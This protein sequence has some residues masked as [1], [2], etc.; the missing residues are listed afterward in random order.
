MAFDTHKLSVLSLQARD[1]LAA[2]AHLLRD[3]LLPR[4]ADATGR[5]LRLVA[6]AAAAAGAA[7][8][9]LPS[10]CRGRAIGGILLI[11]ELLAI[12]VTLVTRRIS[13]N[14]FQDLVLVSLFVQWIA[15]SGAATLCIA[16]RFLD[17]LPNSRALGFAYLLLRAVVLVVSEAAVWVLSLAGTIRPP[18]PGGGLYLRT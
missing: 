12:V 4:V 1:L 5:P 8:H 11:A 6:P 3:Y 14:L 16:R 9:F 2:G 13:T 17:K 10:F 15:L 7:T 18:R